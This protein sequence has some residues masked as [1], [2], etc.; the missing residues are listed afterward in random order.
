VKVWREL[1]FTVLLVVVWA[2]VTA[3]GL[4]P[5]KVL[6]SPA[7]TFAALW[8]HLA[9]GSFE[10]AVTWSLVRLTIG[11]ALACL[12]GVL[13]GY[14]MSYTKEWAIGIQPVAVGL[15]SMPSILFV[16]FA[17]LWFGPTQLAVLAV[18]VVHPTLC[19]LLATLDGAAAIPG[20]TRSAARI[21]GAKGIFYIT[22]V[23]LP[24]ALPSL[25]A[26]AKQGWAQAWRGLLTAELFV[27]GG[28][29]LGR[30]LDAAKTAKDVPTMIAVLL[31]VVLVS[32]AIDSFVF[33]RVEGRAAVGAH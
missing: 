28:Y 21:L 3:I 32:Q 16:P 22:N 30:S 29:G 33:R 12:A 6:P 11:F 18:I 14:A 31:V 8:S 26:G 27:Q 13:F 24:A 20:R 15:L 9:D 17:L 19:M 23:I 4:V 10:I 5:P 25:L 7:T 2:S 1:W